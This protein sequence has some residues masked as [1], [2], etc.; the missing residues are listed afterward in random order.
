MEFISKLRRVAARGYTEF[1]HFATPPR[2]REQMEAESIQVQA[3]RACMAR[4]TGAREAHL[5]VV[6]KKDAAGGELGA[7]RQNRG[8]VAARLAAREK[9]LALAGAVIPDEPFPEETEMAR[10]DRHI[11]IWQ[12]R[13]SDSEER[14]RESQAVIDAHLRELEKSWSRLGDA[15]GERLTTEFRHAASALKEAWLTYFSLRSYFF[16]G[17]SS[18]AWRHFHTKLAL[19]DPKTGDLILNPDFASVAKRWP[20][21]VRTFLDGVNNLRAEIDAIKTGRPV[22]QAGSVGTLEE[23]EEAE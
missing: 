1:L 16:G 13:V 19:V 14:V 17:W 18:A 9:D 10:L 8:V 5:L 20:P 11:R 7:L 21:S 6:A 3:V 2:E 12:A 22:V 23:A 15:I 4:V